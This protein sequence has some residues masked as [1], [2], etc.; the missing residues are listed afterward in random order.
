MC[1][2]VPELSR[3]SEPI[4]N[5]P[6]DSHAMSTIHACIAALSAVYVIRTEEANV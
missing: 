2:G 4:G 5:I 1:G 3:G 6:L